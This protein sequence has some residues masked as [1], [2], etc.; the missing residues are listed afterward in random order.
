MTLKRGCR[1][2]V[3][4]EKELADELFE[5]PKR[6]E[7]KIDPKIEEQRQIRKGQIL[8]VMIA[9][10]ILLLIIGILFAGF[11]FFQYYDIKIN[12]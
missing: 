6:E 11:I 2:L 1:I 10:I 7:K 4:K 8:N 3:E 12:F 5:A 9:V